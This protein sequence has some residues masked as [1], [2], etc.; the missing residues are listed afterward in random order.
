M[1]NRGSN[2]W[3][4]IKI[5]ITNNTGCFNFAQD[6]IALAVLGF[7]SRELNL[8]FMSSLFILHLIRYI[9]SRGRQQVQACPVGTNIKQYIPADDVVT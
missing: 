9:V 6:K 8:F 2:A 3:E 1:G 7:R 5:V 4:L